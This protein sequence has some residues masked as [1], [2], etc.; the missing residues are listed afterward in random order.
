MI[1]S[2]LLGEKKQNTLH[3]MELILDTN[4]IL[5]CLK[6]KIEFFDASN[7]GEIVIPIQ[8]LEELDMLQ[9]KGEMKERELAE[10]A[11]DII[12]KHKGKFKVIDLSKK[13]VDAGIL[14][15]I[16]GKK[17]IVATLDAELKNKLKGK[18]KILVIRARKKLEVV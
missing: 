10:L 2:L 7:F 3:K 11:S 5:S 15:Y 12:S 17:V 6:E 8:V 14:K 1:S 13:F 16:Q 4:F 18:A 9:E